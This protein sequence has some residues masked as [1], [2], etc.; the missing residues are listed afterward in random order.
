MRSNS[1]RYFDEDRHQTKQLPADW[2]DAGRF[3]VGQKIIVFDLSRYTA[4]KD[5]NGTGKNIEVEVT[6]TH[7]GYGS[8]PPRMV[9]HEGEMIESNQHCAWLVVK[10]PFVT[11]W[12]F[13]ERGKR[14]DNYSIALDVCDQGL[15]WRLA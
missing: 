6:K 1:D 2:M 11:S 13:K 15:T 12:S 14:V 4:A 5:L 8:W 7:D 10:T 3:K 9:R